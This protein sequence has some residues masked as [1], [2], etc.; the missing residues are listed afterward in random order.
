M[1]ISQEQVYNRLTIEINVTKTKK[2]QGKDNHSTYVGVVFTDWRKQN[3]D[4]LCLVNR[5]RFK[6][7]AVSLA[8][9]FRKM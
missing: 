5:F 3:V 7:A 4:S 8:W 9:P 2:W 6:L 1:I